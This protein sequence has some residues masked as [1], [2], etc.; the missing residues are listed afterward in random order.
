MSSDAEIL[1]Q[2]SIAEWV[3][4]P[5]VGT[6]GMAAPPL[7]IRWPLADDREVSPVEGYDLPHELALAGIG[8]RVV[9]IVRQ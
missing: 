7:D 2:E 8:R 1:W 3:E 9:G 5:E 4:S 6:F